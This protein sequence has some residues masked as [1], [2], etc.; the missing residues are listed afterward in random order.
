MET[1]KMCGNKLTNEERETL[2]NYDSVEKLWIMDSFVPKHFR[3]ALKQ[4]WAPL[5]QY[6]YEDGTVFGM[7]LTA[8]ERAITIRNVDK[9][10]L[11]E[12][13]LKA[14]NTEDE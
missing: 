14:L 2:L 1:V 7:T 11:S 12:K 4:G 13:Q 10:Q 5:R 9:K 8:P 6:V 3:K